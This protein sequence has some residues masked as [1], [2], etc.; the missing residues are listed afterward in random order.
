MRCAEKLNFKQLSQM[1]KEIIKPDPAAER[2]QFTII[3]LQIHN[4]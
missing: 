4:L 3:S 2:K 1:I